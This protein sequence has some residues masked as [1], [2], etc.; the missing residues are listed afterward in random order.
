[1]NDSNSGESNRDSIL[2]A[3]I[4]GGLAAGVFDL[5]FAIVYFGTKGAKAVNIL[6]SIAGGVL[7]REAAVQGGYLSAS[8]GLVLHFVISFGAAAVFVMASRW[9]RFMVSKP[10]PSGLVYG[11]V[12]YFVMSWVVVPLSAH[13]VREYP[14]SVDWISVAGH[15]VLVGL[16]IALF[17]KFWSG[18]SPA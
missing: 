7:G 12:V 18:K 1:M 3:I 2:R 16:P 6:H 9:W 10:A 4:C 5:A 17:A 11:A 13:T 14:P 15:M 8:L